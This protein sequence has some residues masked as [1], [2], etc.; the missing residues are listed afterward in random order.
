LTLPPELSPEQFFFS[1][2][3]FGPEI[4]LG[5]GVRIRVLARGSL[6]FSLVAIDAGATT[7]THSHPE[8]QMGF[9]L[10]GAFD[11]TQGGE[12]RLLEKGE[13]FYVPPNMEHGG[14]AAGG[15]CRLLDVFTPPRWRYMPVEQS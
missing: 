15:P 13:G 11:R 14:T 1:P 8:E 3:D 9:V 7:P 4:E 2:A 10:E 5:E 6:M 12:R